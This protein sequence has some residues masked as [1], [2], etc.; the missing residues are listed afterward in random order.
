MKTACEMCKTG[1]LC[2]R[3]LV[4]KQT[5]QIA[6][7]LHMIENNRSRRFKRVRALR[8][9]KEHVE[10]QRDVISLVFPE[11]K[12]DEVRVTG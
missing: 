6:T 3:G 12:V 8:A 10:G 1:K 2:K 11:L 5:L 7:D 9:W 4:L